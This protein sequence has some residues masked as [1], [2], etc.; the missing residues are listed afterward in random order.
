MRKFTLA[1][2][3]LASALP[4]FAAAPPAP[5]RRESIDKLLTLSHA[6]DVEK[7]ALVVAIDVLAASATTAEQKE[8]LQQLRTQAMAHSTHELWAS[9]YDRALDDKALAET[10]AIY[11]N[12]AASRATTVLVA[13]LPEAMHERVKPPATDAERNLNAARRTMADMRTLAV[14][15]EARATDTNDYPES[16]DL[17][18]LR[19]LVEPTYIRHMPKR[20]AWGHEL[21]YIGSPGREGYRIV[22]AGADGVFESSSRTL[23][24]T[25]LK[26]TERFEDDLIYQNGEFIQAPRVLVDKNE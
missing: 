21:L 23:V 15:L 4:T 8:A 3:L 16:C 13:M 20:D 7:T 26:P 2:L 11:E 5:S 6:E 1:L 10:I 19:R 14:A 25:P 22:S 17:E 18:T 9:A 24:D 12:P